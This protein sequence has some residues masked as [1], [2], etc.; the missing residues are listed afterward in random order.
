M[1]LKKLFFLFSIITVVGC[2]SD[3]F[4][5]ANGNVLEV[6]SLVGMDVF[7]IAYEFSNVSPETLTGTNNDRWIVYY[8]D[9]DVT[10]E[11]NKSTNIVHNARKGKKPKEST[12]AK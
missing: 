11:T 4:T 2:E 12:W 7:E 1:D 5:T 10:L 6:S 9:I 3:K 8:N